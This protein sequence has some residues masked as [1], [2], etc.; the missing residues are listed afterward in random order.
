ME[1][2]LSE[3][4]ADNLAYYIND[5]SKRCVDSLGGCSYSGESIKHTGKDTEGCY[6]GRLL[7]PEDRITADKWLNDAPFCDTTVTGLVGFSE[8]LGIKIPKIVSDNI[9][10]MSKFQ[11]LHD[12]DDYWNEAGL[13]KEGRSKLLFIINQYH[14]EEKYFEKFLVD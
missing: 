9:P 10:L 12:T 14:L 8:E 5:P 11:L 13:T 3:Q 1:K 6:V 4:L 7:S 2:T